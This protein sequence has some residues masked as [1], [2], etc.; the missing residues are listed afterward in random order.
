MS[1][2]SQRRR[3]AYSLIRKAEMPPPSY[4]SEAWLAL[5]DGSDDKVA[6][7]VVAAE[8]WAVDGDN[9]EG[10]LRDELED[11]AAAEKHV[12]D[13]DYQALATEHRKR[14]RHL[15]LVRPGRYAGQVVR[16]LEQVGAD[17]LSELNERT[18]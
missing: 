9:V 13:A 8:A 1:A 18:R 10:R 6:A 2:T 11:R 16:P 3:W 15:G 14:W 5:P 4:G 12:E 7:V 17:Y